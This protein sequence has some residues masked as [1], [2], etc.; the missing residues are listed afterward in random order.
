MFFALALLTFL[1][2]SGAWTTLWAAIIMLLAA[3]VPAIMLYIYSNPIAMGL[4]D[5]ASLVEAVMERS[6]G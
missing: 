3:P 1:V 4:I 6:R 2:H 5:I